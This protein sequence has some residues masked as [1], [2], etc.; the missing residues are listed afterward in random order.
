[1]M[2]ASDTP[3]YTPDYYRPFSK[4]FILS[5]ERGRNRT[6]NLLIKSQLL[7]Q[8]SYA[9]FAI[10]N[11]AEEYQSLTPYA[12]T[13]AFDEH[14]KLSYQNPP[15][16]ECRN[17]CKGHCPGGNSPTSVNTYLRGFRAYVNWLHQ[18]GCLSHP[19]PREALEWVVMVDQ[20][21]CNV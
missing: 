4:S 1:M 19:T 21:L 9:P 11:L 8:L 13:A 18:E 16:A 10:N 3:E 7:C 12:T 17:T 2:G 20:K 6:F 15:K 5:G 14:S